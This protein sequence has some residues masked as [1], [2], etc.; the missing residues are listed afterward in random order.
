MLL[1]ARLRGGSCVASTLPEGWMVGAPPGSCWGAERGA[2]VWG[3]L[4][5][6]RG[7]ARGVLA[8]WFATELLGAC[9]CEV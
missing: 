9:L 5:A 4:T 3:L 6:A 8:A 2:A 7:A 1:L